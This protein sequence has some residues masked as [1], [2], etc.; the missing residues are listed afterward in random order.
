MTDELAEKIASHGRWLEN[1]I[2]GLQGKIALREYVGYD[3][4]GCNLHKFIIRQSNIDGCVFNNADC[5]NATFLKNRG[6]ATFTGA[7]ITDSNFEFSDV[8]KLDLIG[9]TWR[10]T[11]INTKAGALQDETFF[12]LLTNAF[13]QIGCRQKTF[14]E[15]DAMTD[16]DRRALVPSN[17]QSAVDWWLANREELLNYTTQT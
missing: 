9:A 12:T 14:A 8:D 10:G 17:P 1:P 5:S 15:W 13:I 3:F 4:T 6:A 11:V 2:M 7:N 16:E